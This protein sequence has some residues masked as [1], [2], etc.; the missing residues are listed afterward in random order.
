MH[1]FDEEIHHQKYYTV[2]L[3]QLKVHRPMEISF[4]QAHPLLHTPILLQW[5]ILFHS[6]C[7]TLEHLSM[8]YELLGDQENY[9]FQ[10]FHRPEDSSLRF[11]LLSTMERFGLTHFDLFFQIVQRKQMTTQIFLHLF[12]S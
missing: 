2:F 4:A 7:S 5:V 6:N 3:R 8:K 11:L 10:Y 9:R 12:H 1:Y